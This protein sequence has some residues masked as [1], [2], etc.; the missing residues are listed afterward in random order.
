MIN[1]IRTTEKI[2]WGGSNPFIQNFIEVDMK[3][4]FRNETLVRFA[5][6]DTVIGERT[7]LNEAQEEIVTEFNLIEIRK[8]TI[9]IDA[10]IYEQMYDAADAYITAN[11]PNVTRL[12]RENLRPKVALWIYFTTD[13]IDNGEGQQV[14]LYNTQP[15][16]WEIV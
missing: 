13:T 5:I 6:T 16:Q 10:V 15:N 12:E 2:S 11:Y 14:C 8:K 3:E 1:K 9:D 4:V 7:F